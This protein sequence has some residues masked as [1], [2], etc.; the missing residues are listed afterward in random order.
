MQNYQIN[1]NSFYICIY[2]K[3]TYILLLVVVLAPIIL[4]AQFYNRNTYR[5]QRN[6]ISFGIGLQVA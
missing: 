2:E 4:E 1:V 5:T 6:E 3:T